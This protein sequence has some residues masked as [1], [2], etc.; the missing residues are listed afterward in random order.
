[1]NGLQM[2]EYKSICYDRCYFTGNAIGDKNHES[3][4]ASAVMDQKTGTVFNLFRTDKL[5]GI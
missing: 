5:N 1:M 2:I 3:I 4:K